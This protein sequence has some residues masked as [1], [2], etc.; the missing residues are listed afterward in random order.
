MASEA[1]DPKTFESWE[2]AF[3]FPIPAVRG[4]ERQL[5]RDIDSNREKLRTLVGASYRDLLGTAESIIEMNEEMHT[6]EAY[7]GE[8]GQRCN[9]RLLERKS[10]N[11]RSWAQEIEAPNSARYA[12]ASQLSVLRSCPD[13]ISRLLRSGG[14]VLLAAKVLV[15]SR[16]LHTKL[17]QRPNPPPYLDALRTRLASLRRRLLNRID[18]RFKSLELSIEAVVEAMCAF[19]LATSSSPKDV[20]RHYHHVRLEAMSENMEKGASGHENMFSALRIYVK[21][22]KDTQAIVP[23]QLAHALEKLKST[24]LFKSQDVYPLIALNLDVHERWIGDDIKTFTPYIRHDDLSR[25]ESER[26]LRQWAERG[27]TSFLDGL[28]NRIH[29]VQDPMELLHLRKEILELWLSNHQHSLGIDSAETLDG[30]REVFS[31]QSIR[32]IQ[33]RASTLAG[34]GTTVQGMLQNWQPGM[35]DLAPSLWD[36]S[37]TSMEMS[38]GGQAFRESLTTRLIG[39]NEPLSTVSRE[40]TLFL[41]GIEAVQEMIR[42]M[43]EL[44]W[45]DD[46]NEVDDEDDLLEDRQLL[47]SKDDP[48]LLQERLSDAL[49]E[50]YASLQQNLS[51]SLPYEEDVSRGQK[52]SF[53]IRTWREVRQ[54]FPESYQNDSLGRSSIPALQSIVVKKAMGMT[55]EK[56][57]KRIAKSSTTTL[58]ERPLWEGDPELPVLPSAWT[59]RFLLDLTSSMTS[60]GS[61]IWTTQATEILK[62][63]LIRDIAPLLER[64]QQAVA[65]VMNGY[66]DGNAAD[67]ETKASDDGDTAN[68]EKDEEEEMD[69]QVSNGIAEL[70]T[71][72][73]LVNGHATPQPRESEDVRIQRLFDI[74]YLINATAG[75]EMNSEDNELVRVRDSLS[76]DLALDGKSVERMKKDAGEYWKRT[77][78]LFALLA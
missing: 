5:R 47:L 55:L 20:L 13:V 9:T 75:K 44:R 12:F 67:T 19:S 76:E 25:A 21:T 24:S 46:V 29:G 78:L 50:A 52:G 33:A 18:R 70:Q 6:V 37:M 77:S 38:H 74:L 11:L 58:L 40:Y 31:S 68:G 17:S 34:V 69:Q 63:E 22:L 60:C 39:M 41:K 16:L 61:D 72:G 49:R 53:L 27:F 65:S 48:G 26:S 51:R 3:Q 30:L 73:A 23:G 8:I 66:A 42:K 56:C 59:C 45:V 62:R 1:P 14:S 7:I 32:I 15:I 71:K 28:R 57:A 10:S 54:R 36:S 64:H 43:R 35:S 4:M 2:E